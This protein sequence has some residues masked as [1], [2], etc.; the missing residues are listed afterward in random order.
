M[1]LAGIALIVVAVFLFRRARKA[2]A[3]IRAMTATPTFTVAQLEQMRRMVP[4]PRPEGGFRKITEVIGGAQPGAG[5]LLT[6]ELSKTPCVWYSYRVRRRWYYRTRKGHRRVR[7]DTV[8]EGQ[9]PPS[10]VLVDPQRRPIELVV[11]GARPEA[12]EKPVDSYQTDFRAETV[13]FLGLEWPRGRGTLGFHYEEWIIR[14]GTWLYV[15]GEARDVT[16]SLVIG[17]PEDG[18]DFIIAAKP[19]GELRAGRGRR[20]RLLGAAACALVLVGLALIVTEFWIM[21]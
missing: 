15:L 12:V 20:H 7:W 4:R 16:G 1:S 13:E 6:S 10:F 14:P 19:E 2:G 9:A 5:G 8:A 21:A 3:Q 11:D 18:S 17:K